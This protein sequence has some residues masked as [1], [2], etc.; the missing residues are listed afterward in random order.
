[1]ETAIGDRPFYCI[2]FDQI[3]DPLL[4][5]SERQALGPLVVFGRNNSVSFEATA[6]QQVLPQSM[7]P[8]LD[9]KLANTWYVFVQIVQHDSIEA[10]K[11]VHLSEN[12][13]KQYSV[14]RMIGNLIGNFNQAPAV[15]LAYCCQFL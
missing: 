8:T 9:I 2:L 13:K 1:M 4:K 5:L 12:N 14:L 11:Y 7:E 10:A 3:L 6:C 15:S